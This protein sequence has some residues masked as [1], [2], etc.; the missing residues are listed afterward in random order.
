MIFIPLYEDIY[1]N[2]KH[3]LIKSS[4]CES[5]FTAVNTNKNVYI[6]LCSILKELRLFR[7]T[8]VKISVIPTHK[9]SFM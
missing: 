6:N 9:S 5:Y 2:F 3:K 8:D 1:L 4:L 7:N